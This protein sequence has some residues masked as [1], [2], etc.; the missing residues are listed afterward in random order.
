[1]E[2]DA[3][4]LRLDSA[5]ELGQAGRGGRNAGF[6]L[7][8][9]GDGQP[10]PMDEVRPAAVVGNELAAPERAHEA[11]PPAELGAAGLAERRLQTTPEEQDPQIGPAQFLDE[12]FAEHALI[13]ILLKRLEPLGEVI[14]VRGPQARHAGG[15][16]LGHNAPVERIQQVV[17]IAL[18]VEI[19]HRAVDPLGGDLEAKRAQRGVQMAWR[20]GQDFRIAGSFQNRRLIAD[21]Q[22]H[23]HA[24]PQIGVV[25]GQHVAGLGG[26]V[27]RILATGGDGRDFGPLP[28]D[29]AGD[30]GQ[31][32]GGG[33]HAQFFPPMG[34][35]ADP[36]GCEK[37]VCQL[38]HGFQV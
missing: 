18:R 32:G 38:F 27:V 20:S 36:G 31:V 3:D 19:A 23:P 4:A 10:E 22:L 34:G 24:D 25:G 11:E 8:F 15:D 9:H 12:G 26:D 37:S 33:H 5:D 28:A 14:G 17:R 30:G 1:M 29:V 7:H 6:R 13:K 2:Q 35:E 16:G 21:F